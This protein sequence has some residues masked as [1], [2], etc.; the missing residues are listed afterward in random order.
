M[1]RMTVTP[2]FYETDA[3]GHINN[4]VMSGWFEASREPVFRL[5]NPELN[6]DKWNLILAKVEVDYVAQTHYGHDVLLLTGIEKIG[7]SSFVVAQEAWQNDRLVAKGRAVQVAFNYA[8]Q[9]SELL[10]SE[11]RAALEQHLMRAS[12]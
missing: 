3:L 11:L 10:T 12:A 2:R 9:R 7:N 5:F 1:F 6:L 8:T 4:T